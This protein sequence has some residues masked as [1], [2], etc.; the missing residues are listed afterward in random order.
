MDLKNFV[1]PT[2]I[3]VYAEQIEEHLGRIF[4]KPSEVAHEMLSE[5]VH[6][7][8]HHTKPNAKCEHHVLFTTGMSDLPMSVPE[9]YED[10]ARAELMMY[11]PSE[12]DFK[13]EGWPF[14]LLRH[15]A[16]YVHAQ[17]TWLGDGH[18]IPTGKLGSSGFT[19]LLVMPPYLS[20]NESERVVVAPDGTRV[21][22]Y[23]L[24][25]LYQGELDFKL[26]FGTDALL[27]LF[28]RY[29]IGE[30]VNMRRLN[31]AVNNGGIN[32]GVKF[33]H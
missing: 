5:Y 13:S 23:L 26:K 8:V 30:V 6:I 19:A 12:W 28:D 24:L 15:F 29:K 27:E 4:G 3:A 16:R 31:V 14:D 33:K 32:F 11:L 25:P 20:L 1:F 9:G 21:H 22:L 2:E 17:H 18:T 7:D 10:L